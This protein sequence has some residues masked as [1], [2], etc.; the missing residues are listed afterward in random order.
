MLRL[1]HGATGKIQHIVIIM[2]E[3]QSFDHLF[4]GYPGANTAAEC[5][6]KIHTSR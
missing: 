2:Q 1:V 3:N 5:S 6:G 4:N